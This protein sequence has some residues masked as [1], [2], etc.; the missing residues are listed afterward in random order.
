MKT[1]TPHKLNTLNGNAILCHSFSSFLDFACLHKCIHISG[2]VFYKLSAGQ[3][4][5]FLASSQLLLEFIEAA[6]SACSAIRCLNS[7]TS[8]PL[9]ERKRIW[10]FGVGTFIDRVANGKPAKQPASQP[11]VSLLV[12]NVIHFPAMLHSESTSSKARTYI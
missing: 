6:T 12:T 9:S 11:S 3:L 8:F 7:S 10:F 5:G 1:P 2:F 4:V